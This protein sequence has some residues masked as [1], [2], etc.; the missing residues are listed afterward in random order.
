MAKT[1]FTTSQIVNQLTTS[2]GGGLTGYTFSWSSSLPTISYS[3]NA[4]TPANVSGYV[5]PEGGQYLVNMDA[6]QVATASLAFQLWDDL[7][8][9]SSGTQHRLVQ[10]L[11]PTANITLNY[12]SNTSGNGTYSQAFGSVN[13]AIH[14]VTLA[15]EQVWLS[16]KWVSNGDSGMSPGAYGLL[17][18]IHEI[19]HTL[20]LSHPGVYNAGS[21]GTITYVDSA[22]FAQDNRQYTVM[23][24]FGGYLAGSGWQQDGTYSNYLYPQTPMVYDIAAIQA[25]YGAD[26][27]TRT[28]NTVYGFNC[29]LAATDPE[30]QIYDFA[31]NKGLLNKQ[32]IKNTSQKALISRQIQSH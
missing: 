26:T 12:S 30:R 32:A 6:L 27:I 29:T 14:K 28:D 15:A 7:I 18:M 9:K 4:A 19:G 25:I 10:T 23:S 1:A 31:L 17:T 2:W 24:Y 21:G 20:G 13:S 16:S 5:P 22:V 11:S 8:A 3:I